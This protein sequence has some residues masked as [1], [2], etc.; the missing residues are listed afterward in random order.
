MKRLL[1]IPALLLPLAAFSQTARPDSCGQINR[2]GVAVVTYLYAC[3]GNDD[4]KLLPD[5]ERQADKLMQL[6]ESCFER[7]PEA[8]WRQNGARI[9]SERARYDAGAD[10]SRAAVCRQR[11]PAILQI[12]RRY[13]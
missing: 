10:V 5:A 12:L 6:G 7:D 1:M 3:A 2:D 11:R 8:W 4:S 13:R 9:E